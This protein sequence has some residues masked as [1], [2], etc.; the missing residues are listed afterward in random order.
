MRFNAKVLISGGF[1]TIVSAKNHE[2]AFA[3]LH[4]IIEK[5]YGTNCKNI[6]IE[7]EALEEN[8]EIKEFVE[9]NIDFI[10]EKIELVQTVYESYLKHYYFTVENDSKKALTRHRFMRYLK[11]D[12]G[13]CFKQMIIDGDPRLCF[14]NIKLKEK[15]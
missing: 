7:L 12:Y 10:S 13:I 9:N 6:S 3:M 11:R 14:M 1:G 8:P 2:A 15:R 4:K 5:G